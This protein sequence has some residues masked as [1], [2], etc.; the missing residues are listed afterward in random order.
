MI[1]RS[2]RKTYAI[3]PTPIECDFGAIFHLAAMTCEAPLYHDLP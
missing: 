1:T 3:L 2:P